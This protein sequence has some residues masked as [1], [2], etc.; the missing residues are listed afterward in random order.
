MISMMNSNYAFTKNLRIY[1]SW[2]LY[3]P[4]DWM[5]TSMQDTKYLQG[6]HHT[7]VLMFAFSTFTKIIVLMHYLGCV[8]I[9]IG[10]ERFIDYEEGAIPWTL[11]NEDFHGKSK[12]DL[13][14]FA[15]YWV[16]TVVT[17]VGY[18]DYTG[19][20]SLEYIFSFMIEFF[21]FVIFAAIQIAA[22]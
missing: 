6:A 2:M 4:L 22:R 3:F 7:S 10:S 8:F 19:S 13:I 1:Q 12:M 5:I 18:G 15:D 17:T 14:I 16:T 9:Y 20:T 11:A 21:G